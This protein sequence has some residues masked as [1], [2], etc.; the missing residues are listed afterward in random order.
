[1]IIKS[2]PK[3]TDIEKNKVFYVPSSVLLRTSIKRKTTKKDFIKQKISYL[4]EF[5]VKK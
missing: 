4:I 5:A 2:G 3:N 1:M